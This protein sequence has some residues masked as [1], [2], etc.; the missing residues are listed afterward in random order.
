MQQFKTRHLLL[1][2][3]VAAN[4][5]CT[6]KENNLKLWYAEPAKEWMTEALPL[7]NSYIGAMFFGGIS[8]EQIQ[9]S[10]GSLW[11]G[12]PGSNPSYNFGIKKNAHENLDEIRDL[13][14]QY[15][16]DEANKLAEK[17][18][19]GEIDKKNNNYNSSFGDYGAQQTMGDLYIKVNHEGKATRLK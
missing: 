10:E 8:E 9:F 16:Y 2:V 6:Q 11:A 15:K 17:V 14:D 5:S 1:L 19:I 4:I 13:L 18:L 12:G 3:L 7:G